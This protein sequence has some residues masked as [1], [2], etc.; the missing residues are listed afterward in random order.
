MVI[1]YRSFASRM[2]LLASH[3]H[4]DAFPILRLKFDRLNEKAGVSSH[5]WSR[6][7]RTYKSPTSD[8]Y[9]CMCDVAAAH[10]DD[11]LRMD[12][13]DGE[14]TRCERRV[15]RQRLL[16]LRAEIGA[17]GRYTIYVTTH[18]ASGMG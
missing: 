16:I 11:A 17:I 15:Q 12:T 14:S 6:L 4:I 2:A 18:R 3:V 7:I 8:G 9:I 10:D 13:H 5:R 1:R